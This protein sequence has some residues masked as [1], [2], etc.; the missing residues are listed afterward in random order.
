MINQYII[1]HFGRYFKTAR[2]IRI[3]GIAGIAVMAGRLSPLSCGRTRAALADLT[4]APIPFG[5]PSGFQ[6]WAQALLT[7]KKGEALALLKI[8]KERLWRY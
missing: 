4:R 8:K 3:A 2:T 1:A 6:A 7:T 5:D